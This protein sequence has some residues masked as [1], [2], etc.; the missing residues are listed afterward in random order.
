M[1]RP[2]LTM[3]GILGIFPFFSA[4]NLLH[5]IPIYRPHA[6]WINSDSK[7]RT[8]LL[9]NYFRS[10]SYFANYSRVL[11]Q[12]AIPKLHLKRSTDSRTHTRGSN[13]KYA[14]IT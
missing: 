8:E 10:K 14:K 9:N 11:A 5:K 1:A 3:L 2:I 12:N 7:D 6:K 13:I 4:Q